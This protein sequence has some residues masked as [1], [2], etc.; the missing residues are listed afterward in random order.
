MKTN[1]INTNTTAK[2]VSTNTSSEPAMK[3]MTYVMAHK[4]ELVGELGD[5]QALLRKAYLRE[6][7]EHTQFNG[8]LATLY[9]S[10]ES[11]ALRELLNSKEFK[12]ACRANLPHVEVCVHD[13]ENAIG[14]Y[15]LLCK[16]VLVTEK[17]A[18]K[19]VKLDNDIVKKYA[20]IRLA[21]GQGLE[22]TGYRFTVDDKFSDFD[23]SAYIERDYEAVVMQEAVAADG[24]KYQV[25]VMVTDEEGKQN[26]KT[27]VTKGNFYPVLT[28]TVTPKAFINAVNKTIEQ[29]WLM[30]FPAK[31]EEGAKAEAK[32]A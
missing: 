27:K 9:K 1:S 6:E 20:N 17:N 12:V 7:K 19:I 8:R 14:T 29:M 15:N 26:R 10:V 21:K 30:L 18:E 13:G 11:K 32:A 28:E 22:I 23:P 3:G 24:T 25:P 2:A 31:Q 16:F 4:S 5:V